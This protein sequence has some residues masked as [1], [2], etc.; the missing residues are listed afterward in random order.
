[1]R[2]VIVLGCGRSGTSMV[3]GLFAH[4]GYSMGRGLFAANRGNPRGIFESREVNRINEAILAP[5]PPPGKSRRALTARLRERIRPTY[6]RW[7]STVPIETDVAAERRTP[8]IERRIG[9]ALARTPWC[10]KDPRFAYTLDCWRP[11]LGDPLFVC[12]FREPERTAASILRE[13][14]T[15]DY[16]RG[17]AFDMQAARQLWASTYR[18]I[19]ERHAGSGRW[20]FVHAEQVVEGSAV[21]R[22][23]EA[24]G[25]PLDADF[26][27]ASLQSRVDA[28]N[29]RSAIDDG[30]RGLY[31]ELCK[32]ADWDP[33]WSR[34]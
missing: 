17:A 31:V 29:A 9:R 27:D 26:A 25:A 22:L 15:R 18:W 16:L 4:A 11:Q 30:A 23:E 3:A 32:R 10:L 14:A 5:W 20:L 12:V 7:L 6:R 21:A 19:L 2:N 24:T 34:T 28:R 8:S 1:M 13:V 33:R